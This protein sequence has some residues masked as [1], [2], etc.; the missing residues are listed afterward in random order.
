MPK[1]IALQHASFVSPSAPPCLS[2]S[3][4]PRAE[5][6]CLATCKLCV[7]FGT[8][9]P[10]LTFGTPVLKLIALQQASF[11]S[12]LAFLH[13]RHPPKHIALQYPSFVSPSAS[14]LP[15]V[16]PCLSSPSAPRA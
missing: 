13:L 11:V 9:V 8:P 16:P 15:S 1:H 3:S 6:H 7:A 14:L 5:A 4:A 12:P 2:S 10:K